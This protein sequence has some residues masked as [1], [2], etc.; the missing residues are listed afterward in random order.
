MKG[1]ASEY[2]SRPDMGYS[3]GVDLCGMDENQVKKHLESRAIDNNRWY[4]IIMEGM[5]PS[6]LG[7][8]SAIKLRRP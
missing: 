8:N 6:W 5:E 1:A 3:V 7:I 2:L 4:N